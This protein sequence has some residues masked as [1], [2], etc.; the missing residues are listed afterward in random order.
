MTVDG[1]DFAIQEPTPFNPGWYSHKFCGPGLRYEVGVAIREPAIVWTNGPFPC[2]SWPDLKIARDCLL[3]SLDDGERIVADSGY[4]ERTGV[5]KTPSG[6]HEIRDHQESELRA[7]H[8]TVNRRF[9]CW[10]ALKK[11]Y[12]HSSVT[13]GYVFHA[14]CNI[15]QLELDM[16]EGKVFDVV[17]EYSNE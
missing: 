8:E 4:K 6:Y 17:Y 9:K 11:K 13:H 3:P 16:G 12:R 10:G 15:V 14:I 2:G 7:R 1:T 5:F